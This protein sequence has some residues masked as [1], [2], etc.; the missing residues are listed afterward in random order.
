M[1]KKAYFCRKYKN[2]ATISFFWKRAALSFLFILC[3]HATFAAKIGDV[4]GD[5]QRTVVD[6]MQI[7]TYVMNPSELG[8]NFNLSVAD[9]NHDGSITVV[10]V[11]LLVGIIMGNE[12]EDPDNPTLD[13]DDQTGG[14]PA[15]A[16]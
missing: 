14:D 10:D 6:V 12:V 15:D 8:S 16:L 2:M 5:G 7:V 11:M 4:N 3:A 9:I 13:I 1:P